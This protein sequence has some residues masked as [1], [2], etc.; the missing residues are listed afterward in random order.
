MLNKKHSK[1]REA[2]GKTAKVQ[3]KSMDVVSSKVEEND[4]FGPESRTGENAFSDKTDWEN[5]DFIYVY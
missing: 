3:D 5:E 2:M 1:R 4:D